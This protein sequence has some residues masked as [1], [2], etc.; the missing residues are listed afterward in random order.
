MKMKAFPWQVGHPFLLTAIH[1]KTGATLHI[2]GTW[3]GYGFESF[4]D[5][6]GDDYL[7]D[8]SIEGY[9]PL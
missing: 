7:R 1:N 9:L 8:R 3:N 2:V 4:E 6:E 5:H